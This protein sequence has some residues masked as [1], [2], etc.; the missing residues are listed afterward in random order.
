LRKNRRVFSF[1][2]YILDRLL[3]PRVTTTKWSEATWLGAHN[4]NP[5]WKDEDDYGTSKNK[6]GR[7]AQAPGLFQTRLPDTRAVRAEQENP[8]AASSRNHEQRP[9]DC[10]T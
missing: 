10:F 3:D 1:Q 4:L 9:K 8:D 2:V 7:T 6:I 5:P